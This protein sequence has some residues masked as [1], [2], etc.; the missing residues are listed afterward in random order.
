MATTGPIDALPFMTEKTS[1][2]SNNKGSCGKG[3]SLG[4]ISVVLG[5]DAFL[6]HEA[7]KVLCHRLLDSNSD[8]SGDSS[9][10]LKLIDGNLVE[11]RHLRDAMSERSLF[12]TEDPVVVVENAD[13]MVQRY[14]TELEEYFDHPTQHAHLVLDVLRWASTTRL[15]KK[16]AGNGLVIR[17]RVPQQGRE[18]TSFMGQLQKWLIFVAQ[19]EHGAQLQKPAV[20]MLLNQLPTEPGILYQEVAKL[21]LWMN[22]DTQTIDKALITEHVGNW[23]ARKTWD[24]IDAAVEG[25]AAEAL[26]QLDRL[27]ASGEAPLAILP[28]IAS[29][30]RRFAAAVRLF[31]NDEV[32]Q[33]PLTLRMA[34]E[35][36]GIPKFKLQTAEGQLRQIGRQRARQIFG[37]LLEADLGMKGYNAG[38]DQS[39]R[40]LETLVLRLSRQAVT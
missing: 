21:A 40:V 28:Q 30:L 11:W 29:T 25:R 9:F 23:R 8:D 10:S 24:M 26:R 19:T 15:A 16:V 1:F 14:R 38:D 12:S 20:E 31:E 6:R 4:P 32:H 18:R 13:P 5:D 33:Q 39:R 36:A 2:A 37:W 17:C 7:R 27:L 34:L 35:K 22:P 3:P